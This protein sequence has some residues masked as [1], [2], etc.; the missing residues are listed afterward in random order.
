MPDRDTVKEEDHAIGWA[1][2]QGEPWKAAATSLK[3]GRMRV[4]TRKGEIVSK[5]VSKQST[6]A[7]IW[8]LKFDGCGEILITV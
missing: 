7:K 3:Y 8:I 1:Y 5:L 6:D 2:K 4:A